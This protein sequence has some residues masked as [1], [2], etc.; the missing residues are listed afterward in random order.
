MDGEVSVNSVTNRFFD[1]S[2]QLIL[3]LFILSDSRLY[4]WS[5]HVI[6]ITIINKWSTDSQ[7]GVKRSGGVKWR[8]VQTY[9]ETMNTMGVDKLSTI[10]MVGVLYLCV[11]PDRMQSDDSQIT[12]RWIWFIN[13]ILA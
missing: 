13:L 1:R 8:S 6:L 11:E 9:A 3:F 4:A 2:S 12:S 10:L 5:K 7:G